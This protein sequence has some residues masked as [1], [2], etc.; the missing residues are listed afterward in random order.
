MGANI[1]ECYSS[2]KFQRK[3]FKPQHKATFGFWKFCELNFN[4]ML[5]FFVNMGPN[6]INKRLNATPATKRIQNVFK[7]FLNYPPNGPHI[8]YIR[9]F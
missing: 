2:C 1:S 6:G 7:I 4:I 8:K 5:F 3:I 9:D